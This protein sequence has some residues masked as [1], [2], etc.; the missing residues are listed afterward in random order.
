MDRSCPNELFSR[1]L[2]CF[3]RKSFN[4]STK[5]TIEGYKG[6][7]TDDSHSGK[8]DLDNWEAEKWQEIERNHSSKKNSTVQTHFRS[9]STEN[10][11]YNPIKGIYTYFTDHGQ[12]ADRDSFG[13]HVL[14]GEDECVDDEM[15]NV[16][17]QSL[18]LLLVL[19]SYSSADSERDNRYL[20]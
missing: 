13:D 9:S 6:F 18:S 20:F 8:N 1:L 10:G 15:K 17:E 3:A 4:E 5:A 16:V 19:L 7:Q 12:S 2:Q 14:K 11:T